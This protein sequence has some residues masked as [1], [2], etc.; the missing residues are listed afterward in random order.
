[1]PS[2]VNKASVA[3]F[4]C[5]KGVTLSVTEEIAANRPFKASNDFP[6]QIEVIGHRLCQGNKASLTF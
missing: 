6:R 2:K 3:D 1:M 5:L 4:P